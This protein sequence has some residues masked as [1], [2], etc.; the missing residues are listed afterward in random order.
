MVWGKFK[1]KIGS[2]LICSWAAIAV[3]CLNPCYAEQIVNKEH[4]FSLSIPDDWELI[5]K[6]ILD[7]R[8]RLAREV[9][10]S[11]LI[12][13]AGFQAPDAAQWENPPYGYIMVIPYREHGLNRQPT[14]SELETLFEYSTAE[15][16]RDEAGSQIKD[17]LG[18]EDSPYEESTDE[19]ISEMT[20]RFDRNLKQAFETSMQDH[21]EHGRV[22]FWSMS[23]FGRYANVKIDLFCPAEPVEK[24]VE[25]RNNIFDSFTF[26]DGFKFDTGKMKTSEYRAAPVADEFVQSESLRWPKGFTTASRPADSRPDKSLYWPIE[27]PDSKENIVSAYSYVMGQNYTLNL[28]LDKFPAIAP[29]LKFADAQFQNRFAPAVENIKSFFAYLEVQDQI[30]KRLEPVREIL[31][32][33]EH[34][35]DDAQ[36]F[37]QEIVNR[38]NGDIPSPMLET[39]LGFHPEYQNNPAREFDHGYT[40]EYVSENDPKAQGLRIAIKFPASWSSSPGRRPHVLRNFQSNNGYG[41]AMITLGVLEN[42]TGVTARDMTSIPV[43]ELASAMVDRMQESPNF[44]DIEAMDFSNALIA[45][46]QAAW[47]ELKGT[48][49][50][51]GLES[52]VRLIHFSLI[53]DEKQ[54]FILCRVTPQFEG[55]TVQD[56]YHRVGE[57]LRRILD[58]VEILNRFD[59]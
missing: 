22:R 15:A 28:L 50:K 5:P 24:W 40:D 20:V 26:E 2:T 19:L 31:S 1:L 3:A 58:S 52:P 16:H 4:G 39:L 12:Y 21:P 49:V 38:R 44:E 47:V 54:V 34:T 35:L 11:G 53:Y 17:G 32:A 37:A 14:L 8:E 13:A 56:S 41:G 10:G 9:M 59:D 36:N 42:N 33:Q 18:L 7:I 51:T 6:D 45:G 29:T 57:L 48:L 46:Q 25:I 43:A 27:A 30:D 23:N 55:D